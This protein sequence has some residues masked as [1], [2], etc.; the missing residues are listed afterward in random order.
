MGAS[1]TMRAC[2]GWS[3]GAIVAMSAEVPVPTAKE[4]SMG[5]QVGEAIVM[6]EFD[7]GAQRRLRQTAR[8][9]AMLEGTA[10]LE[11]ELCR[12]PLAPEY[13]QGNLDVARLS[14]IHADRKSVSNPKNACMISF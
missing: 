4:R 13:R 7:I 5:W 11:P 14:D 1:D 3:Q 12:V 2:V 6:A 9:A 10:Q 8:G